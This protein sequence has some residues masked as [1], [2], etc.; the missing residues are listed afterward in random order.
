MDPVDCNFLLP[1]NIVEKWECPLDEADEW[2]AASMKN[3]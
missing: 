1:E 2:Y 3:M